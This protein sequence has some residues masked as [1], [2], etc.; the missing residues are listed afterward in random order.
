MLKTASSPEK[1]STISC[2]TKEWQGWVLDLYTEVL[3]RLLR[4]NKKIQCTSW[5]GSSNNGG[6]IL[7]EGHGQGGEMLHDTELV[8]MLQF[9]VTG[10][11]I[12]TQS[13]NCQVN[14]KGSS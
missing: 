13:I 9:R 5:G 3:G 14:E 11:G 6:C 1:K 10:S 12:H 7:S 8:E 4:R 2:F